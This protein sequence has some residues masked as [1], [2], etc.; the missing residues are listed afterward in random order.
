MESI[1]INSKISDVL[2]SIEN[3]PGKGYC[4]IRKQNGDLVGGDELFYQPG[5]SGLI[6]SLISN[7]TYHV[8]LYHR[9]NGDIVRRLK[10]LKRYKE[11]SLLIKIKNKIN[12]LYYNMLFSKSEVI[13]ASFCNYSNSIKIYFANGKNLKLNY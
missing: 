10:I 6:K 11:S 9:S 5:K 7:H 4:L 1:V 2:F 12:V 13:E 3:V 8:C